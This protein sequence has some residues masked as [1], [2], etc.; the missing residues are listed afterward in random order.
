M[1]SS[2]A[3]LTAARSREIQQ[4]LGA[5]LLFRQEIVDGI[6]GVELMREISVQLGPFSRAR[7]EEGSH[8]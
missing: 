7:S 2:T 8:A 1:G 6:A 5:K 3:T 4:P